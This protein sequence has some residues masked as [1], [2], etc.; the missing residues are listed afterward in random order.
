MKSKS[1]RLIRHDICR[2]E[3][4]EFGANVMDVSE[5]MT[6]VAFEFA[7]TT[8]AYIYSLTPQDTFHFERAKPYAMEIGSY[9]TES[10]I[11]DIIKNDIAQFKNAM[12]SSHFEQFI[13]IDRRISET[14]RTFEDLY[15]YYNIDE[16]SLAKLS[17]EVEHLQNEIFAIKECSERVYFASNP[18][19]F[20]D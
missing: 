20:N 15:L 16:V 17:A 7:E 19:S 13:E 14:V 2:Q 9:Q 11:V 5:I 18:A 12:Q 4:L 1:S 8:I 10:E 6:Y 3:L